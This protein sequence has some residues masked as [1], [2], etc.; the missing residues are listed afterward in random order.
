MDCTRKSIARRSKE[1]IICL[2]SA[3]VRL[4]CEYC[5]QFWAPHK[6]KDMDILERVQEMAMKM[7]KRMEHL[8][9]GCPKR[10]WSWHP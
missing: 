6:K 1:V 7:I 9:H 4:Q 10:L 8:P 5:A 3:L 2:Y